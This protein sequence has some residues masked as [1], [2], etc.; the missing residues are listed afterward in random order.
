[1]ITRIAIH[2]TGGLKHDPL[3]KTQDY[4]ASFINY[5]HR[6][7]FN[8]RS[9][10]GMYGGYNF[11]I[12]ADGKVTQFR[13]IGE[14][15]MAQKGYNTDTI[16]ICLAGNFTKGVENPTIQQ[17]TALKNLIISL[18]DA[19]SIKKWGIIS[20]TEIKVNL[21]DIVPHR[22]IG[23]TECY[24]SGLSD[25]WARNLVSDFY[26]EKITLLQKLLELYSKLL[27]LRLKFG[28]ESCEDNAI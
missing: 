13:K 19:F 7:R 18:L 24:G 14:E 22:R 12:E 16:S 15:T 25:E 28:G 6:E 4:K 26:K 10:L 1:M 5:I 21:A 11:F 17:E 27:Q 3:Y 20:N 9:Q 8:M 23:Y 2:H